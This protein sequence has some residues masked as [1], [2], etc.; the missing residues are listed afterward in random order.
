MEIRLRTAEEFRDAHVTIEI[1]ATQEETEEVSRR[2]FD[3]DKAVEKL[4]ENY[5]RAT[6]RAAE[7]EAD[8]SRLMAEKHGPDGP[9]ARAAKMS[10]ELDEVRK[11]NSRLRAQSERRPRGHVCVNGCEPNAHV[12][13]EGRRRVIELEGQLK[14]ATDTLSVREDQVALLKS[15]LADE[16][17]RADEAEQKARGYDADRHS[18]RDRADNNRAWA[19]REAARGDALEA[20]RDRALAEVGRRFTQAQ[21]ADQIAEQTSEHRRQI[22]EAQ[23]AQIV[24]ATQIGKVRAQVLGS[25]IRRVLDGDVLGQ[26]GHF[27]LLARR[28]RNIRD[29]VAPGGPEASAASTSQA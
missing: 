2:L 8:K 4:A 24:L 28:I 9:W 20:E 15:Q 25:E 19:E 6:A 22:E 7:L 26:A 27:E 12:A 13:F 5:A 14:V 3:P 10:Q 18:E 11:E 23:Q 16:T 29:I 17:K 1:R 21:L